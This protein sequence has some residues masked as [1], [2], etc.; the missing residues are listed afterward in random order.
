MAF[1]EHDDYWLNVVKFIQLHA[2]PQDKILAPL[3][4]AEKLTGVLGYSSSQQTAIKKFQWV[5][6]QK[7]RIVEIE[8]DNWEK[9]VTNKKA[10]F[11]NA[12]FVIFSKYKL[13]FPAS[14]S[15]HLES[16]YINLQYRL[17]LEYPRDK[18]YQFRKTLKN[19][20]IF[21]KSIEYLLKS[22][23]QLNNYVG[24]I[25]NKKLTA[26][27]PL[28]S[29][30]KTFGYEYARSLKDNLEIPKNLSPVKINLKS[31]PCRQ[32]D[33]E[34]P[35]FWYWCQQLQIPVVYHRKIWEFTYI[36]QALYERDL[37]I[38]GKKGLGFG[39]GEEPIPSLLASY[40]IKIT[41]TDLAPD[42]S[43]ARGWI[44]T[45]QNTSSIEKIRHPHLC[46][47]ETFFKNVN[48]EYVDMNDIPTKLDEQYDFCWSACALEHLGSIEKGLQFI[49]NSLR[50]LVPGGICI[51]T[52]E[53]NYLEA[54]KTIDNFDTVLFRKQDFEAIA[55]RLT[56]AGHQ[57]APLDFDIGSGVLDRFIDLP[58]YMGKDAHLKLS[59]GN[60]ASTSF[61][62]V[63]R[64]AG[65]TK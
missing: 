51:H 40:N 54:E 17:G 20:K 49:E 58:P 15:I 47:Q 26:K 23:S 13:P 33:I 45:N 29:T 11:A 32:E 50:T 48:L 16:F 1:P 60:F 5:V 4:F 62:I 2:C 34:S 24:K 57:V 55:S 44:E 39:C 28:V 35:W 42:R 31:Q 64:K 25:I 37:L 3:E 18:N 6:V 43:A 65:S 61:G 8:S 10:V 22:F 53:F 59:V 30:I 14:D 7:D 19:N 46:S 63:V 9:I 12:V 52:T 27:I 56:A 41:A 38:A 21:K 36:L